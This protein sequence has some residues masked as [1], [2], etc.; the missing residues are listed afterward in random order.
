MSNKTTEVTVTFQADHAG[1]SNS[2]GI[3][4]LD[5]NGFPKNGTVL[6]SNSDAVSA[7]STKQ[8]TLDLGQGD[9]FGYFLI[10]NGASHNSNLTNDTAVTFQKD[11]NGNYQAVSAHGALVGEGAN[12]YFDNANLNSDGQ[13]HLKDLGN[14]MSGFE[15]LP[16]LGDKDFDDFIFNAAAT[17]IATPPPPPPPSSNNAPIA[18]DDASLASLGEARTID[19]LANDTDADGDALTITQINGIDMQPGWQTWIESVGLVKLNTDQTITVE[20]APGFQSGSITYTVSD[21]KGGTDTGNVQLDSFF[22]PPPPPPSSN[23]APVAGDD[24][25]DVVT[26]Q[27]TKI[28]VLSNDTDVDGDALT[29]TQINGVDMQPGWQTWVEGTGLVTVNADGTLDIKSNSDGPYSFEYTVSDGK[30]GTDTA[31]V[32]GNSSA[33]CNDN[34]GNSNNSPVAVNDVAGGELG[35]ART[36]DVLSNDTDADGDALAVTHINGVSMQPGWQTWVDGVGLV[37]LNADQ[38]VTVEPAPGVASASFEYTASDGKG[39]T[40]NG[41][42]NVESF[43][44]D[45][46]APTP[47]S[48]P[49]AGDDVASGEFGKARTVDVLSNDTDA[50]GDTLSITHIS[51]Q[52]IQPNGHVDVANIGRVTLN[53]DNTLTVQ[54]LSGD[55]SVNTSFEYTVSDGKGGTDTGKVD[56]ISFIVD[57]PAPTSGSIEGTFFQDNNRNNVDDAGDTDVAGQRVSLQDVNGSTIT[58]TTTDA[59]G[60]Y[61]FDN[62]APGDYRVEFVQPGT[63]DIT[64]NFVAAD[65]GGNDAIDSDVTAQSAVPGRV[66]GQTDTISVAAGQTVSNVDAGVFPAPQNVDLAVSKSFENLTA[67]GREG[68]SNGAYSFD[69]VKFTITVTNNSSQAATGVVVK[70]TTPENLDV[71]KP[72]DDLTT[73]ET[74]KAW[75]SNYWSSWGGSPY[76]G[77]P[78]LVDSTNGNVSVVESGKSNAYQKASAGQDHG[79]AEGSVTWE[80]GRAIQPGETVTLEYFGMRDT[81][82]AY[83][84]SRG[85]DFTTDVEIIAVDQ[86]D[87]NSSNDKDAATV[88]WISPIA[89]DLNGDGEIGVTGETSSI[90]KDEDAELGR[91]VEFDLDADGDLDTVEWF[92]GSGDGILV[93]MDK[94]GEDGAIDGSALFG[95]EGGKYA[96]GYEKLGAEDTN[97]DG[98]ITGDELDNLGLWVDDGDAVLEEGEL[99]SA[100]EAGVTSVSTDMQ[101]VKDS[102]GRDLMQSEAEVNGETVM[103]EDVWFAQARDEAEAEIEADNAEFNHDGEEMVG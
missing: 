64:S 61:R 70:D 9:T 102:E 22:I 80:L 87:T 4:V 66:M 71:W 8:V 65:Q 25:S 95:D 44:V 76:Q 28:N 98:L 39:G 16:N 20:P 78:E 103:T 12:I 36:V 83:N 23:T 1:Y 6:W 85:T 7:G 21:G 100:E 50:D 29:I 15:D 67:G 93:N 74:G 38:T 79:K 24:T 99:V 63:T 89:V 19:V 30:G 3:F 45:P 33:S 31:T 10:P 5:Q 56:L 49:V 58:T 72:G 32:S 92:D 59:Q 41:T 88:R 51:G 47:N 69:M 54:P 52:A 101:I 77:S 94:I 42:V 34:G 86:H 90:Q 75:A 17:D 81:I 53:T 40:A 82:W 11:G 68:A 35:K 60:N 84:G 46:P 55:A 62:V 37:K 13:D 18:N 57:P 26:G 2:F 43:I 14:G 91:T 73:S 27:T 97:N 96:N 48:A